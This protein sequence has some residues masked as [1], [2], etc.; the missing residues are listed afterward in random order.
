[1]RA[2][3]RRAGVVVVTL[4]MTLG[5]AACSDGGASPTVDAAIAGD[6]SLAVDGC[7]PTNGGIEICDGVDNDCNGKVDE[8]DDLSRDARL[9]VTCFGGAKG[10]CAAPAHAGKTACIGGQVLCT[11]T[12]VIG[13]YTLR[14]TC[15]GLDDDCDGLVDD[16]PEDVGGACGAS[17]RPPCRY[18]TY[19]CVSGVRT[20]I[21]S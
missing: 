13:P 15:N 18:G 4:A 17:N 9:G 3:V 21:R 19:Q 12:N 16:F 6:A 8:R 2:L 10:E 5:V 20:E 14:E 11:G 1:V 7:S